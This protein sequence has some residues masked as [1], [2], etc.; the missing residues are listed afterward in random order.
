MLGLF[1]PGSSGV[2][3][4]LQALGVLADVLLVLDVADDDDRDDYG[5]KR[6]VAVVAVGVGDN[7]GETEGAQQHAVQPS[8]RR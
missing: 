8:R 2:A 7:L 4:L 6:E 5:D 1:S 3:V